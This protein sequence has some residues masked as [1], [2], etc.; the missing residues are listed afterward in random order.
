MTGLFVVMSN[1]M[2]VIH[3]DLFSSSVLIFVFTI[4]MHWDQ[5]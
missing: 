4:Y 1:H 2:G 3:L 5:V